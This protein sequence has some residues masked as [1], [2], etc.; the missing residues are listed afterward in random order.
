MRSS[1]AGK[2]KKTRD[3]AKGLFPDRVLAV[4]RKI[5]RGKVLTYGQVA[6]LVGVPRG[7]RVVGGVL[8]RLGPGSRLPWQRVINAQGK[9]STY[10]V[11]MGHEQRRLLEAEGLSFNRD[12][13][14]DLKRHQW[15]PSPR[16]LK[17]WAVEDDLAA[18]VNRRIPW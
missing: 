4:V 17:E 14:I 12:D 16:L 2:A 8:F 3:S 6:T 1:D 7:A 5:P 10:R 15:W 9:I 11:G 13:A 18:E